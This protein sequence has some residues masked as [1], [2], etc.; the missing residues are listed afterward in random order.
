MSNCVEVMLVKPDHLN[1]D[2]FHCHF[3]VLM[4][5]LRRASHDD[6]ETRIPVT[7]FSEV[8][9]GHFDCKLIVELVSSY[10]VVICPSMVICRMCMVSLHRDLK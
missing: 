10:V 8:M 3:D 1:L 5:V 6:K 9:E 4:L 7:C 2:H